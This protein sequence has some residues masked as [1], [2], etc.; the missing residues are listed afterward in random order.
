VYR[1]ELKPGQA[2]R[3]DHLTEIYGDSADKRR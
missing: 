3:I 1:G 2:L